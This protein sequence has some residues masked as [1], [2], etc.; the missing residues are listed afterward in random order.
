MAM[1]PLALN[2]A[3]SVS[4]GI[5]TIQELGFTDHFCFT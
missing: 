4:I 3:V 1:I 2:L 5:G